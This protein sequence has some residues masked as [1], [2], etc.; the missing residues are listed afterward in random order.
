MTT[1]TLSLLISYA[2]DLHERLDT[3][4]AYGHDEEGEE[5]DPLEVITMKMSTGFP[6]EHIFVMTVGGPDVRVNTLDEQIICRWGSE[7][8]THR[9]DGDIADWLRE[10]GQS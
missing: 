1:E 7:R 10:Q 3:L 5:F 9:L 4:M 8:Y 2:E 6:D